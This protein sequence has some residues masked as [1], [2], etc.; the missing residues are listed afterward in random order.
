MKTFNDLFEIYH[1]KKFNY[2]VG[3]FGVRFILFEALSPK[4]GGDNG[5]SVVARITLDRC[6]DSPEIVNQIDSFYN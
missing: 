2:L 4:A 3:P 6:I 5:E 1:D